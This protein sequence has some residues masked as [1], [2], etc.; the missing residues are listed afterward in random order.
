LPSD[1]IVS[2]VREFLALARNTSDKSLLEISQE[3]KIP[4][5]VLTQLGRLGVEDVLK[6]PASTPTLTR[7]SAT[8]FPKIKSTS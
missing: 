8:P 4:L 7:T 1:P 2:K 5:A 3:L 6:N